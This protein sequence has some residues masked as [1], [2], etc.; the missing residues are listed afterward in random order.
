MGGE[1]G[2]GGWRARPGP[3]DVL[4]GCT[5]ATS[6]GC[7]HVDG[8]GTAFTRWEGRVFPWH[9]TR[10][11]NGVKDSPVYDRERGMTGRVDRITVRFGG[12]LRAR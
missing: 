9:G 2:V 5:L 10:I 12:R 8:L 6:E 7:G 4:P 11:A 3:E 1:G